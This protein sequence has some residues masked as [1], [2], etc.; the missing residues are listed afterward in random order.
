MTDLFKDFIIEEITLKELQ[1]YP[2]IRYVTPSD[3]YI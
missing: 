1:T 3:F 2:F